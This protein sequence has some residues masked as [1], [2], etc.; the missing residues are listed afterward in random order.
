M[1]GAYMRNKN[2]ATDKCKWPQVRLGEVCDV[3]SGY[4][5]KSSDFVEVGIPVIKI[6]NIVSPY[7]LLNDVQFISDE[8]AYQKEKYLLKYNDIL[9]SL[10]GSNINQINS[11]VGKVGRVRYKEPSVLNQRVGKFEINDNKKYDYNFLYYI[12]SQY[13]I[14][15]LLA[16]SAQGSANQANISPDQIKNL[17]IPLPPLP[18]QRAIAATLS[19]LDDKIALNNCINANLEAQAQAIFKSWF[20]DFEPFKNGKFVDSELG[21]IPK[22]WKM[23]LFSDLV[24]VKYGKAHQSL[25]DGIFPVYGSGGLMRYA[26][27]YL[28]NKES[29]LIPRKGTLDNVMYVKEPFWTVD[30]MFYTEMKRP[31]ISS[32]VYQFIK[33]KNLSSMNAG[34]AV[35]SMTTEIL[36]ALLTIV[37]PDGILCDYDKIASILY[38]QMRLNANQSHIL[39]AIRDTLLP[40]LMGG[41]IEVEEK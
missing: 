3:V 8:L 5:Y 26:E 1:T 22:E 19:C 41:E 34:T 30:T 18:T 12:V 36:N 9:I 40:K 33:Q 20:V 7:I 39:A 6:K 25:G 24:N 16:T 38:D 35:P 21:Q 23:S 28:Y 2:G 32:F 37:P 4:A 10:T 13:E 11:A 14:Q 27:K 15:Y 29:V 31:R 17:L